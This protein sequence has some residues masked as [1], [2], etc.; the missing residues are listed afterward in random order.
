MENTKL[1]DLYPD[2]I[3]DGRGFINEPL[4]SYLTDLDKEVESIKE[5]DGQIF[6]TVK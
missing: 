6:I 2:F 3:I 4:I 1:F 5:Q